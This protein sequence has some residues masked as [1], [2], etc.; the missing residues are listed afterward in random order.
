M[1][2]RIAAWREGRLIKRL[3]SI[4]EDERREIIKKAFP[5]LHLHGDPKKKE[6]KDAAVLE[7]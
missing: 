6:K 1:K 5:G 2:E 4:P 7:L 3:R